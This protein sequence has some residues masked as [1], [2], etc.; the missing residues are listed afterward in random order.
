MLKRY[1]VLL[2]DW[3]EDYI[4]FTVDRFDLSFSEII[5]LEICMA[6]LTSVKNYYPEYK[7]GISLEEIYG[8]VNQYTAQGLDRGEMYRIISSIYFEARKATEFMLQKAK[9]KKKG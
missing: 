9:Q 1:Q 7:S 2:P 5:R 8:K 3:L 6:I 4:K